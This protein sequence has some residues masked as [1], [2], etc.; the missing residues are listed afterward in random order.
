MK[1]A[2]VVLLLTGC[3]V[4]AQDAGNANKEKGKDKDQV[5]VRGCVG[6]ANGDYILMK[7]DP[8][9]TYELQATGK[10]RLKNYLGQRVEVTGTK[11]PT[12]S[13]SSDAATRTSASPVTIIIQSIKT[14]DKDCS[15][16]SVNR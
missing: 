15:E 13:S 7:T 12:L 11:S 2:C 14:L 4:F 6:R 1:I 16:P 8:G 3:F 9:N 10:T 5:T